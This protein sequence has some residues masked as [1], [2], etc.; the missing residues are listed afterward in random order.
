MMPIV[1]STAIALAILG[2]LCVLA[3]LAARYYLQHHGRA[4]VWQPNSKLHMKMDQD[5]LPELEELVRSYANS[6]GE[7]GDDCPPG[8]DIYR[9]LVIGGSAAECFYLDKDSGWPGV[10]T[11]VLGKPENLQRLN[12]KDVH[13]GNIA[14][15]G[16]GSVALEK[17]MDLV[18]PQYEELDLILC[19][20]GA[21]D[22]LRWFS[23]GA[24]SADDE[25][26]I[27]MA[28]YVSFVPGKDYGWHPKKTALAAWARL[29]LKSRR[30]EPDVRENTGQ[31]VGALRRMR[32]DATNKRTETGDPQKMLD[33]F[34][35]S[36]R[37]VLLACNEK[38]KRVVVVRQ[39][40]FEKTH[41]PEEESFFWNAAQGDPFKETCDTYFDTSMI[42][43]RMQD[44]DARSVEVCDELGIE[45][46]DLLP[47]L[48]M[49]RKTFY[50]FYHYTP[51]GAQD[52]GELIAKR[53]LTAR[54]MKD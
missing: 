53:L 30:V 8:Q 43:A 15:A 5:V 6:E 44:M 26:K 39:P 50:D 52:I 45:H 33:R 21:S 12:K 7:R 46:I 38:S 27:D 35:H 41:T 1:E 13:L 9:I 11:S 34:A 51:K 4:F 23:R 37:R 29:Q 31:R 17:M 48:E 47:H 14:R 24:T 32:Q 2:C 16:L 49:S 20:V 40:W 18:L 3:E 22:V 42:R 10:V 28:D 54:S 19:M 25:P 36:F